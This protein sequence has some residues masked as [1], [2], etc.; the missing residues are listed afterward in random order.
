MVKRLC[1]HLVIPIFDLNVHLIHIKVMVDGKN[2]SWMS[3]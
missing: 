3:F 2:V 1:R